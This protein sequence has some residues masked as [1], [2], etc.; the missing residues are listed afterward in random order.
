MRGLT[1][2]ADLSMLPT[3]NFVRALAPTVAAIASAPQSPPA[4][5]TAPAADHVIHVSDNSPDSEGDGSDSGPIPGDQNGLSPA[6]AS[7]EPASGDQ[8]RLL[9]LWVQ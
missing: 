4:V 3:L 5:P 2:G 7:T 1:Q 6:I 9:L 8:G